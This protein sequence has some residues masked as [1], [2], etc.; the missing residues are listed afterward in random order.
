MQKCLEGNGD[1]RCFVILGMYV[2]SPLIFVTFVFVLFS[3]IGDQRCPFSVLITDIF[4]RP[5]DAYCIRFSTIENM[6][7]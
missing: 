7:A 4:T 5:L 1:G 3:T 6:P 2:T